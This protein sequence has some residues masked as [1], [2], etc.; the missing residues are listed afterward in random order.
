M[1]HGSRLWIVTLAILPVEER[2]AFP[3]N[4]VSVH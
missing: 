2:G 1:P 4:V 3:C